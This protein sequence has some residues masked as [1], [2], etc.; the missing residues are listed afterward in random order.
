MTRNNKLVSKP[1]A[2]R[3]RAHYAEFFKKKLKASHA[4]ELVAAYF[5]YKTHISMLAD[6]K[7]LTV[8]RENSIASIAERIPKLIGIP[9]LDSDAAYL[10]E[11]IS[12]SVHS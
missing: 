3:L 1:L 12:T 2:D 10:Y 6:T 4:S 9:L 8:S 11:F 7:L 5:G